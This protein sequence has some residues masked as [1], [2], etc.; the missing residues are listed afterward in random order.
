MVCVCILLHQV[1]G[2]LRSGFYFQQAFLT[3]TLQ[4]YAR[5]YS[6]AIDTVER[7]SESTAKKCTWR[8]MWS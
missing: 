6:V 7:V 2:A 1:F 5:K 3:G 4:N 8:W